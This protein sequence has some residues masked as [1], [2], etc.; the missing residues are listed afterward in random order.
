MIRGDPGSEYLLVIPP[1]KET[2]YPEFLPE[3]AHRP[4]VT[5]GMDQLL[6]HLKTNS[7]VE[8]LDLRPA[9]REA[10]KRERVYLKT[11]TH[12]NQLGAFA[13]YQEMV[14]Q[15]AAQLP[16]LPPP[17]KRDAF[18]VTYHGRP[19]GDLARMLAQ[20]QSLTEPDY[21]TLSPRPGMP[22]LERKRDA[23]LL[24]KKWAPGEEPLAIENP[25]QKFKAVVFRDSFSEFLT[26]FLGYQF[27]RIVF[28]W[29]R[30]WNDSLIARE[31]PQVVIDEVL[32]RYLDWPLPSQ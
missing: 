11:D 18:E 7:T 21:V 4:G 5:T 26:S 3:W 15:L 6:A 30:E 10:R 19:G 25:R 20:E 1:N 9:L 32:E 12:W 31:E 17:M 16:G 8:I 24:P 29:Q 28:I 22:Q 2:I 23:S 27:N 14:R 13:G